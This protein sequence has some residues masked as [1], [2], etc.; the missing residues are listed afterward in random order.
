MQGKV[1]EIS[2]VGI[3]FQKLRV[4]LDSC[5]MEQLSADNVTRVAEAYLFN[6]MAYLADVDAESCVYSALSSVHIKIVE[7][8]KYLRQWRTQISTPYHNYYS[9]LAKIKGKPSKSNVKNPMVVNF[10]KSKATCLL[11]LKFSS[12]EWESCSNSLEKPG[13]LCLRAFIPHPDFLGTLTPPDA[14]EAQ[15]KPQVKNIQKMLIQ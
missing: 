14:R 15:E 8:R 9:L 12:R 13:S 6:E 3:A 10:T 2:L 4:V 5:K 7:S 11:R 1:P